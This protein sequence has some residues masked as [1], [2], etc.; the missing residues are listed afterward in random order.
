MGWTN[1]FR[2]ADCEF[3]S[4]SSNCGQGRSDMEGADLESLLEFEGQYEWSIAGTTHQQLKMM[5]ESIGWSYVV[6]WSLTSQ[7]RSLVWNDGLEM[8]N[9]NECQFISY[10]SVSEY[11]RIKHYFHTVYK[12]CVFAAGYGF[13]GEALQSGQYLWLNG[14]QVLRSTVLEQAQFLKDAQIETILFI[15]RQD[16]VLELGTTDHVQENYNLVHRVCNFFSS[17]PITIVVDECS[18]PTEPLQ[19]ISGSSIALSYPVPNLITTIPGVSEKR[20]YIPDYSTMIGHEHQESS[21]LGIWRSPETSRY[22]SI[23][24]EPNTSFEI[25]NSDINI[26]NDA[27]ESLNAGI[28]YDEPEWIST[29]SQNSSGLDP[30]ILAQ[31]EELKMPSKN[32][33]QLNKIKAGAFKKY[34]PNS[35]LPSFKRTQ[36]DRCMFESLHK[37]LRDMHAA[38]IEKAEAE[39]LQISPSSSHGGSLTRI[40]FL[41]QEEAA[42]NHRI[43]ERK[44]RRK[45]GQQLSTLRS[46][47]P[48]TSKGD[49]LSILENA[50]SYLKELQA[51][52]EDLEKQKRELQ[53]I[54]HNNQQS[55]NQAKEVNKEAISALGLSVENAFWA[56]RKQ[57]ASPRLTTAGTGGSFIKKLKVEYIQERSLNIEVRCRKRASDMLIQILLSLL[58][59][60][61][62][63]SSSIQQSTSEEMYVSMTAYDM[64][65][66]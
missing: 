53:S 20:E 38:Q 10:P 13:A 46:L 62:E 14:R 63:V 37:I 3:V 19:T 59:M 58:H 5:L 60:G 12:S 35:T 30:R 64:V 47:I 27:V 50:I 8:M 52:V 42:N 54:I 17:T 15:P 1:L 57:L 49:K 18:L 24:E 45:L 23:L 21:A 7:N 26:L 48:S 34:H 6:T 28:F 36:V 16:G 44:R 43:A 32:V 25:S 51:S 66:I 41:S 4:Q 55:Q 22:G 11:Q 33:T 29:S 61:L 39:R 31:F 9:I 2:L 40:S 65:C 56:V